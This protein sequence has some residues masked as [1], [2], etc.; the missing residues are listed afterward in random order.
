[1]TDGVPIGYWETCDALQS[2]VVV[3]INEN[4]LSVRSPSDMH[5]GTELR[6]SIFFSLGNEFDRFQALSRTTGKELV[7]EE[8]WEAYEYELEFIYITEQDRLKLRNFLSFRLAREFY[9]CHTV[10]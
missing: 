6:I 10:A 3:D 5:I 7:S 9:S 8:G 4:S 1:M 2:G